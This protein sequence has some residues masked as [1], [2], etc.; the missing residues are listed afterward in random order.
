MIE[1]IKYFI[2][3]LLQGLTEF[4]PISSSGHVELYKYIAQVIK[5]IS[6]GRYKDIILISFHYKQL[7]HLKKIFPSIKA[8]Y[9]TSYSDQVKKD[10][11]VKTKK[12]LDRLII[13]AKR[14]KI[15]GIDFEWSS[16]LTG[17]LIRFVKENGLETAVWS[18]SK[19]DNFDTA[20]KCQALNID[21][22][23]TNYPEKM[24]NIL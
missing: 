3:G 6:Q 14:N 15:D 9:I 19:D 7:N 22:L 23:T 1:L 20:K 17:D 2:L 16:F 11:L 21:Y 8:F 24:R 5:K 13:K 4:F 10:Y 18:Y 12:D